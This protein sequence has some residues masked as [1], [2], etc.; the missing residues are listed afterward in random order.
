[1]KKAP[2]L[3][4][5]GII[6][7]TVALTFYLS[8]RSE[9][10]KLDA[11]QLVPRASAG[12]LE[13]FRPQG[14]HRLRTDTSK[15]LDLIIAT[16]GKKTFTDPYLFSFQ[17]IG[18]EL[19][20]IAILPRSF[21][22]MLDTLSKLKVQVRTRSYEGKTLY[23]LY[24]GDAY[25]ASLAQIEGIWTASRHAI[26]VEATIRQNQ[27]RDDNFRKQNFRLFSLPAVKQDDGNYYLGNLSLLQRSDSR[28]PIAISH[29]MILDFRWSDQA[30]MANGFA[31][32]TADAPTLLSLFSDQLPVSLD[33]RKVLT[34]DLQTVIHFGFSD[35]RAWFQNREVTR[36]TLGQRESPGIESFGFDLEVFASAIDNEMVYSRLSN[37][38]EI[39]LIEL[40]EITKAL[41]QLEKIR[42]KL[43]QQGSYARDKYADR[44]IHTLKQSNVLAPIFWPLELS[45]PEVSYAV[46]GNILLIAP[47]SQTIESFIEITCNDFVPIR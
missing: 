5:L 38:D 22:S 4:T 45:A 46:D 7:S 16:G 10:R 2:V 13:T 37:G 26:L 1:M 44:T 39:V 29:S 11:W 41:G 35:A 20:W 12:V 36:T 18:K 21:P 47:R 6:A 15:L 8:L 40:K 34:D 33:L 30:L 24:R 14:M 9:E 43:S 31:L 32:D 19:G 23:D 27:F 3:I 28:V 17:S 42:S 25:W